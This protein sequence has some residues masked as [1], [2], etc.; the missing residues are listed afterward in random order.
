MK[1]CGIDA[2]IT[3]PQKG[4]SGPACVGIVLL[5]AEAEKRVQSGEAGGSFCCNLKKWRAVMDKY[6]GGAFMYYTTLPT[7]ALTTFRNVMLETQTYGFQKVMDNAGE[8]GDKI[9]ACLEKRG[10]KSVAAADCKSPTVVV[11][12]ADDAKMVANF[13]AQGIQ[14]AGGVPFM[15]DEP[16]GM[17]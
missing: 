2:L 3:A 11:S 12:Y 15:L 13:K 17:I 8:L 7:D 14:I 5:G 6:E 16:K 10:F 9:R 1:K 4:W